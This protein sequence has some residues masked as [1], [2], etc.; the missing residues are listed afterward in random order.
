MHNILY[1][2]FVN[3]IE[4]R[5]S[6]FNMLDI[7]LKEND[8]IAKIKWQKSSFNNQA[9]VAKTYGGL[10]DSVFY[11]EPEYM[12]IFNDPSFEFLWNKVINKL[13]TSY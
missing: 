6:I 2:E 1:D 8:N 13:C 7:Q 12:N 3:S 10:K 4:Y 11:G 5:K 9:N